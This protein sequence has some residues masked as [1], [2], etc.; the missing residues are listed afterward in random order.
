LRPT[1]THKGEKCAHAV[2]FVNVVRTQVVRLGPGAEI[3][4]RSVQVNQRG[5]P[6]QPSPNPSPNPNP[7]EA[8]V[9]SSRATP[10]V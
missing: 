10:K 2:R 4:C 8:F 5:I 7:N 3:L 6:V 1:A 9:L